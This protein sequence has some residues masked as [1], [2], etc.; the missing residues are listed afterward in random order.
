MR[1]AGAVPVTQPHFT[2]WPWQL[3]ALAV[4]AMAVGGVV[5][6]YFSKASATEGMI[7]FQAVLAAGNGYL[8]AMA[9]G[10][11][12]RSVIAIPAGGIAGAAAVALFQWP[13]AILAYVVVLGCLVLMDRASHPVLGCLSIGGLII[14]ALAAG[15]CFRHSNATPLFGMVCAYPFACGA[16]TATMP[17]DNT[18]ARVLDAWRVGT[19][20]ALYGLL[21]GFAVLLVVYMFGGVLARLVRTT[22]IAEVFVIAVGATAIFVTNYVCVKCV[23]ESVERVDVSGETASAGGVAADRTES[24][25]GEGD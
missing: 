3:M 24:E 21:A 16:V 22:A 8:F 6:A 13:L 19:R 7:I 25:H 9:V 2:F 1:G 4:P 20:A 11:L 18:L 23:F 10:D 12:G 14:F 5:V 15:E 17:V